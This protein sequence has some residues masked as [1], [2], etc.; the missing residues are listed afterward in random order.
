MKNPGKNN[1]IGFYATEIYLPISTVT[2]SLR[3]FSRRIRGKTDTH[4]QKTLLPVVKWSSLMGRKTIRILEGQKSDGNVRISELGVLCQFARHLPVGGSIFEIGTFDGRTTLNLALNAPDCRVFTLDLPPGEHTRF[5]VESG[6]KHYIEK[7]VSGERFMNNSKIFPDPVSRITQLYGDSAEFDFTPYERRCDL[8]FVDGSHAY[9]YAVKD[10]ETAFRLRS[11]AGV[12]VWH[13]Y[14]VWEGVTRALEE[15]EEKTAA[16]LKHIHGTSL[17][18][19][20]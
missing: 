5:A 16:G 19:L 7:S 13:D 3:G 10:S 6:E 8:V 4:E 2:D 9:D 20:I 17:V 18:V 1:F 15:V 12:V 11:P 14:G